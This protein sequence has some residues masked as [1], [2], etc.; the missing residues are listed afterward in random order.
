[1]RRRNTTITELTIDNGESRPLSVDLH[2]GAERRALPVVI[3]CHGFLGYKRWGFF[4]YLSERLAASGLHVLTVSFSMNGVEDDTGLVTRPE[5]FARNTVSREV[6]DLTRVCQYVRSGHLPVDI[7]ETSGWGLFGYS[8][9]AAVTM[10]VAP[11]FDEIETLVTWATPSR[12]DRYSPRRKEQWKRDGA[13]IFRDSRAAAPLSLAYSYY[14]DIAENWGDVDLPGLASTLG[15]PHLMV[16][17]RRDA[18]VTLGEAMELLRRC[19]TDAVQL[20]IVEGCGHS[21]GVTH[22]MNGT[23]EELEQAVSLTRDWLA[24][25]L[26][27]NERSRTHAS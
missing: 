4:P 16:H 11:R 22:P 24:R 7:D 19:R 10:I 3:M 20:R 2:T 23:S 21:F 8:R 15:I 17:C 14:E 6:D 1:M 5:E 9:G 26:H 13:L 18:A 12:L 25:T 27:G